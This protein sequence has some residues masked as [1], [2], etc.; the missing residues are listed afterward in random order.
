M[1]E[2]TLSKLNELQNNI[3]YLDSSVSEFRNLTEDFDRELRNAKRRYQYKLTSVRRP[4]RI[5]SQILNNIKKDA[6]T[7]LI[8]EI[9]LA[10]SINREFDAP[11][12]RFLLYEVAKDETI[13]KFIT[14][15]SGWFTDMATQIVFES[16]AGNISDYA[17]GI[18]GYRQALKTKIGKGKDSGR[19]AT[20]SWIKTTFNNPTKLEQTI[21]GRI[22]Y[23][24]RQAPFWQILDSGSTN[25]AS[26]RGDG[27]YNPFPSTPTDFI[28]SAERQINGEFLSQFI[29]QVAE[30]NTETNLL[31]DEIDV[32]TQHQES[33]RESIRNISTDFAKSRDIIQR[34]GKDKSYISENKL[35]EAIRKYKAGEE[36]DS[37]AIELTASGAPSRTRISVRRLEGLIEAY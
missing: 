37:T 20:V 12:Y 21:L 10:I 4:N 35:A 14:K 25:L 6:P 32:A 3:N 13:Y 8:R 27:S 31:R 7:I 16:V 28:G 29:P 22:G 15:G 33:I 2:D 17:R 36:F 24:S 18:T 5:I 1:F 19:R 11:I 34:L 23:A 9:D 30:W 26:D